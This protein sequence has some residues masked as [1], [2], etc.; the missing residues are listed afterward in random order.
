MLAK[1]FDSGTHAV[2]FLEAI[3]GFG[4][5]YFASALKTS[6]KNQQTPTKLQHRLNVGDFF[7]VD[8]IFSVCTQKN[9]PCATPFDLKVGKKQCGLGVQREVIVS[10]VS[11]RPCA[12]CGVNFRAKIKQERLFENLCLLIVFLKK[13]GSRIC[14]QNAGYSYGEYV[15]RNN[16]VRIFLLERI[17]LWNVPCLG[18]SVRDR[19]ASL[20]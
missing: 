9:Y 14:A 4:Q 12:G 17:I 18:K 6:R 15:F 5:N 13:A 16:F 11:C 2:Y 7:R 8:P 19:N 3:S 20:S 10:T 1:I